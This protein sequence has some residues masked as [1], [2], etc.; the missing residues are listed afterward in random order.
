MKIIELTDSKS[1]Q[2][3]YINLAHLVGFWAENEESR[4]TASGISGRVKETPSEIIELIANAK[5]LKGE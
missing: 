2:T 5:E 1:E 3:V 4:M